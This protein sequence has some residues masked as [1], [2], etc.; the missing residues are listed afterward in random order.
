VDLIHITDPEG[1]ER[2]QVADHKGQAV[3]T[4]D[5]VNLA[6]ADTGL[7]SKVILGA[8]DLPTRLIDPEL[9]ETINRYTDDGLLESTEDLDRGRTEWTYDLFGNVHT[10]LGADGVESVF[11]YDS[12]DRLISRIDKLT[13]GDQVSEWEYDLDVP[14][15]LSS[16]T[17]A[18]GIRTE[19]EYEHNSRALQTGARYIVGERTFLSET[20]Y[21]SLGR[22]N[23][24]VYPSIDVND[25]SFQ[26][27]IRPIYDAHSGRQLAVVSDD[28][29][30][31]YWKIENI[32]YVNHDVSLRFGNGVFEER[33]YDPLTRRLDNIKTV[34]TSGEVM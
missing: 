18:T 20:Q 24:V 28:Q 3:L 27:A 10:E 14:G 4:A 13:D 16:M 2:V 17:G 34:G 23:R 6:G 1:L 22:T 11:S 8:W 32:D 29:S 25:E 19:F 31:E 7:V 21:D 5:G 12:I 33:K 15:T 9:N 26:F 30:T